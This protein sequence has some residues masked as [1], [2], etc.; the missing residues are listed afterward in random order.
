MLLYLS[1]VFLPIIIVFGMSRL[2]GDQLLKEGKKPKLITFF[3][4][5]VLI[6][7][8]LLALIAMMS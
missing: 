8:A 2:F 4:L 1:F 6:Y 5:C 3:V 7:I